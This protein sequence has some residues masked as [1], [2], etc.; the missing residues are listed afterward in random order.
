MG[1]NGF[2]AF[3]MGKGTEGVGRSRLGERLPFFRKTGNP[4]PRPFPPS[5]TPPLFTGL[6]GLRPRGPGSQ[7]VAEQRDELEGS[8]RAHR[9]LLTMFHLTSLNTPPKPEGEIPRHGYL[10]AL[11]SG[12]AAA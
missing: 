8:L 9:H 10:E 4:G 1:R 2:P 12:L 5:Q 11:Q 7:L 3:E 6:Q